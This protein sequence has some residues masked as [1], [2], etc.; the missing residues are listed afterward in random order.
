MVGTSEIGAD[1][2]AI[3]IIKKT[4]LVPSAPIN[5]VE[6]LEFRHCGIYMGK[7]AVGASQYQTRQESERRRRAG[8]AAGC[9]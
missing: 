1:G 9:G 8:T 3:Y 5:E 2:V 6:F 4:V 7:I